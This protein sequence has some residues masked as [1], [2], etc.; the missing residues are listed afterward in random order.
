[1]YKLNCLIQIKNKNN[2][3]IEFDYVNECFIKTSILQMTDTCTLSLPRNLAFKG[4]NITQFIARNDKVSV[5]IG[6]GDNL[7]LAFEGYIKN[8]SSSTPINIECENEMF[9]LKQKKISAVHYPKL[10]LK[11]FITEHLSGYTTQIADI[12]L[13]EVRIVNETNIAKVFDYFSSNYPIV[14]YFRNNTLFAGL[15][16]ALLAD[17]NKT[18]RI[19]FNSP[20]ANCPSDTL[21]FTYAGDLNLQVITKS[22]LPDNTKLEYKEP[23][24]ATDADVRTFFVPTAKNLDD[25]KVFAKE[26]L[27]EK[28]D[29]MEGTLTLMG[30][31]FVTKGDLVHIFDQLNTERNDKKFIAKEV[32]YNFGVNG[33]TQ[34]IVLGNQIK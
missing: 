31:P 23:D 9:Q 28:S 16:T 25:L 32:N 8:I 19:E 33:Y 4:K 6:Y 3:T 29:K 20:N 24:S 30:E 22:I 12:N 7:N 26:K 11:E 18:H 2:Q 13:G 17:D 1:M 10:T 27:A 34:E 15:P 21:V 5:K 14:F